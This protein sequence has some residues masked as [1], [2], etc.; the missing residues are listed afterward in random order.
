VEN[1]VIWTTD[2]GIRLWQVTG[3]RL[4]GNEIHDSAYSGIE[5][6]AGYI[7]IENNEIYN[8]DQFGGIHTHLYGTNIT[9]AN[10]TLDNG[11]I[12]LTPG[13]YVFIENNV[14]IDC[15]IDA[16]DGSTFIDIRNNN[17]SSNGL[18]TG[19]Y[20][21]ND[22]YFHMTDSYISNFEWGVFAM[23]TGD[24]NIIKGSTLI[25]NKYGVGIDAGEFEIINSSI[26][27]SGTY[28]F[29]L[30]DWSLWPQNLT[31]VTLNTTFDK[32]KV[33]VN[34]SK[35]FLDVNW[36]LHVSVVDGLG[37]PVPD[38]NVWVEDN[39]N[40]TFNWTGTTG[41]DGFVRWIEV[42]E[43]I[44]GKTS[45][46]N[47]SPH[48]VVAW[49]D[50]LAG[51]ATVNMDSSKTVTIVLK[52][53]IVQPMVHGFNWM[54]I[55]AMSSENEIG[56]V[57]QSLEGQYDAVQWYDSSDSYDPWKHYHMA[58]PQHMN[59][60]EQINHTIGILVHSTDS[61]DTFVVL[62]GSR[63][64]S[65]QYIPLHKGWNMVGY[66]SLSTHNQT[67]A[68]N[69]LVFGVHVDSVWAF[70]AAAQSWEDIGPADNFELG[71]GYW[72]HA[73]QDCVWEVPL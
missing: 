48:K 43:Y 71:K 36:Y 54:S 39:P 27:N 65:P 49:N 20:A 47:F 24:K 63:P 64:T 16:W 52:E 46:T 51:Y 42:K 25:N 23:F 1:N 26:V 4:K 37:N 19:A 56:T 53:G 72:I 9:I 33:S 2:H 55:P 12:L 61:E 18:W 57:L 22:A 62:N 50:T 73:T 8:S 32:S 40:G 67:A 34:S 14:F 58:K 3:S 70:E 15:G 29:Y 28:D 17:L 66:P 30:L 5:L 45:I 41:L 7:I 59:D 21:E 60:L 69:N 31:T 6:E 10:N 35:G 11:G 38:A 13:Y 68:L 44:Q